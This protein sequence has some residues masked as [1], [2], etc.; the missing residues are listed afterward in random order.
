MA[1]LYEAMLKCL[2]N[3]QKELEEADGPEICVMVIGSDKLVLYGSAVANSD[4]LLEHM[5]LCAWDMLRKMNPDVTPDG[6]AQ[7]AYATAL[8]KGT[9]GREVSCLSLLQDH[10]VND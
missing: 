4:K 7:A 3:A 9:K 10:A 6:F 1:N 8:R 5:L 2:G